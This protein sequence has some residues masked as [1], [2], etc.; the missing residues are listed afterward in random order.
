MKIIM[1]ISSLILALLFV[2]SNAIAQQCDWTATID[3]VTNPPACTTP[4]PM[5]IEY[6]E[7]LTTYYGM[8]ECENACFRV[9]LKVNLPASTLFISSSNGYYVEFPNTTTAG[10]I[11]C[12][13]QASGIPVEIPFTKPETITG[14]S[15]FYKTGGTVCTVMIDG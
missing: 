11:I 4:D 10:A 5:C 7:T 12:F 13:G 2:T 15:T 9:T 6:D 14:G 1:K 8:D 3:G